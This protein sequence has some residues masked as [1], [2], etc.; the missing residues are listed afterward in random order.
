[1]LERCENVVAEIETINQ[2][3]QEHDTALQKLRSDLTEANRNAAQALRE[4]ERWQMDWAE[5]VKALG[6]DRD[7]PPAEAIGVIELIDKLFELLKEANDKRARID[8]IE[9]EARDFRKVV[10]PLLVAVADDLWQLPVDQAVADLYDR[11]QAASTAQTKLE[12]WNEQLQIEESNRDEARAQ[13][14]QL[15]AEIAAMCREAQCSTAAELPN[16]ERR[17][18]QRQS[19]ERELR[20]IN[21]KLLQLAAAAP[22][23]D[24]I[25]AARR[26]DADQL[27][28]TIRQLGDEIARLEAERT[29]VLKTIGSEQAVLQQMDGSGRA[30]E[31]QE[32]AEELLARIRSDA[33]QYVR[34]RL[35]S[36]V[37]S[38]VIERFRDENKGPVLQ[39][40]SE[41]FRELTLGSFAGLRADY[42]EKGEAVLVGVRAGGQTAV[43]VE[44]MSDGTCDQLYLA[45]RLASLETYFVDQ[46]PLPF[47]VDDIL[48][49]FDDDRAIAALKALVRLSQKTQVI[50]FTHHEHLVHI[51]RENLDPDALFTHTLDHR[52]TVAPRADNAKI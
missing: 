42:N 26:E 3:R 29:E 48:I 45:L 49:M 19:L 28:P 31:A 9:R 10:Q 11:L 43:G 41:L 30:A 18:S 5:A 34:L 13:I 14:S 46:R 33:E 38:R 23:D 25:A 16:A 22:L 17:S 8:G 24:F 37:L 12:A 6:L 2:A 32:Q 40:A 27:Q 15:Q 20:Q 47:I 21:E 39:R 1:M 36:T 7:A 44:G 35:A 4:L 52:S 50:F 51:A